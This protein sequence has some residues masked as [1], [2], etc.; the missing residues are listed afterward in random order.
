M[1]LTSA[2]PPSLTTSNAR[3]TTRSATT[4]GPS[5]ASAF[6]A[7]L[8]RLVS[9]ARQITIGRGALITK[10]IQRLGHGEAHEK[11]LF[12][13]CA[14]ILLIAIRV[15]RIKR[16]SLRRQEFLDIDIIIGLEIEAEAFTA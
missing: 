6:R 10:L 12:L 3:T 14:H 4:A 15:R 13:L 7:A 16:I 1:T 8:R 2:A 11:W 9:T 5:A